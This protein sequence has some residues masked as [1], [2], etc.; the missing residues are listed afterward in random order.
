VAMALHVDRRSIAP[1]ELAH[2][3]AQGGVLGGVQ[4]GDYGSVVLQ[5]RAYNTVEVYN[6]KLTIVAEF[7][8]NLNIVPTHPI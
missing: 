4:V 2:V 1:H 6:C 8:S 7:V 3:V 5:T